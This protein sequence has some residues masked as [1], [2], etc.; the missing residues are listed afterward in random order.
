MISYRFLLSRIEL[1]EEFP[2][3]YIIFFGEVHLAETPPTHP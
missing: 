1:Y 2:T 3:L